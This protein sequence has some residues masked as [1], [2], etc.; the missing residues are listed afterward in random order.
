MEIDGKKPR[1]VFVLLNNKLQKL[2]FYQDRLRTI[3]MA[4]CTKWCYVLER[5]QEIRS[6][7]AHIS[8]YLKKAG[9]PGRFLI[10]FVELLNIA[11]TR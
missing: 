9:N 1:G 8:R 11:Q 4:K 3:A 6:L 7:R 5:A 10:S 2:Q